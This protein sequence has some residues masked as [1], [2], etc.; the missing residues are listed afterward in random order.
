MVFEPPPDAPAEA[1]AGAEEA[2]MMTLRVEVDIQRVE[3]PGVR[4]SSTSI[5]LSSETLIGAPGG[6]WEEPLHSHIVGRDPY[7]EHRLASA[8]RRAATRSSGG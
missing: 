7:L 8:I 2:P 5:R 6:G 4:P 3:R 1:G